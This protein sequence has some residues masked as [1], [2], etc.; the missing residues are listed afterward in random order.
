LH[1]LSFL[2]LAEPK[3]SASKL[4]L[5]SPKNY[6][7]LTEDLVITGYHSLLVREFVSDKER[8]AS[9]KALG[10]ICVTD[11]YYRLPAC[12]DQRAEVYPE[13][14]D[15][16]IYHLALENNDYYT[17]YGIYANGLLVET[18]SK[19]YILELSGMTLLN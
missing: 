19:R 5:C 4:Y 1:D 6:P 8:D 10:R 17:N 3:W 12:V 16:K 2:I 13:K 18:T 15:F 14:G 7:E 11:G 9:E